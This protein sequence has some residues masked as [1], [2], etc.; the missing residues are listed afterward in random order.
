MWATTSSDHLLL[1]DTHRWYALGRNN[2]EIY[3]AVGT[4]HTNVTIPGDGNDFFAAD[5]DGCHQLA[6]S[7]VSAVWSC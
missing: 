7:W 6:E 5:K 1:R 3:H 4:A 2:Y